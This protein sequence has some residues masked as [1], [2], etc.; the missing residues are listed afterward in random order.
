MLQ[1]G[2]SRNKHVRVCVCVLS[3]CHNVSVNSFYFI[4]LLSCLFHYGIQGGFDSASR[5]CLIQVL[6]G[7]LQHVGYLMC[8]QIRP[9]IF[10]VSTT[11]EVLYGEALKSWHIRE[12]RL[13]RCKR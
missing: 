9:G 12:S 2:C 10:N 13:L 8:F 6:L 1:G 7:S 11:F 4:T 3:F 5:L